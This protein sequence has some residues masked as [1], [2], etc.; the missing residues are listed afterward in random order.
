MLLRYPG[1]KTKA[2]RPITEIITACC[3]TAGWD[4]EY[5]EPFVGAGAIGFELLRTCPSLRRVWFNDR[6]PVIC[7]VWERVL[8]QP[9][10]LS[11][12]ILAFTPGVDRFHE[13]KRSLKGLCGMSDVNDR[14]AVATQKIACHQ[15]S[16]NGM[17]TMSGGPMGGRSQ[18]GDC[19]VSSRYSTDS[20][21]KN[22]GIASSLLSGVRTHQD[23]CSNLDFEQVLRAPG[24][25]FIYL[26]PPYVKQGPGLYQF[27]FDEGDHRRLA[28]ALR[29]ESRP[30]LLSY[31]K[32]PMILSLYEHW[33]T[34]R[35]FTMAY[36]MGEKAVVSYC[37]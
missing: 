5:R 32:H 22:V 35:E 6:D 27:S 10:E 25:A 23:V 12:A 33:A 34:V 1:S 26:D 7:C 31:D 19:G 18:S 4:L 2:V 8:R 3:E 30:W 13:V 29:G 37:R 14:L 24:R 36:S 17:G 9:D 15:M 20:L 16:R 28:A 11:A 21:I